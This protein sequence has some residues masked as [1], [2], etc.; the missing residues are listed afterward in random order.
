[1]K[2]SFKFAALALLASAAAAASAQSS[3]TLFG[4]V[5]IAARNVKNGDTSVKSLSSGGINTSRL[6]V[7]G[8]E[9]LGGG[10]IA[11]FWLEMGFNADTGTQSDAARYFNRRST[12]SLLGSFGEVRL[13]RDFSPSYTGL[14]D[15]DTFGDNGVAASS[16]FF[17]KF[18]T[19]VDTNTRSDNLVSYMLP[20]N[21]GGFYG[22][23]SVAPGEATSGKKYLGGRAGY[24][25]GPVNLSLAY[26]R[27]D[28]SALAGTSDDKYKV[29]TLG[30]SYDLGVA[31]LTGYYSENKYASLKTATY[32]LGTI[33]PVTPLASLKLAYTHVNATGALNGAS[34][35]KNDANQLAVGGIYTLS[36]R[37]A[38][39]A[40]YARVNNKG[41]AAYVVDSAPAAVAGRN[42][43]GYELGLR[44]A[45]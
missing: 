32:S 14:S 8:N 24:A 45:F 13:G 18:G 16:K 35:D 5:D 28:V 6:G 2:T 41:A 15:F 40:T 3:V 44:H 21:L 25:A 17:Q 37:T 10:L 7:R 39:Y 42:S 9:D 38:V 20:S 30:A 11:G 26:A 22:Q 4:I 34:I 43:T 23:L 12:A 33:V 36:K 31:K 19:T 29:L 27:T 1:M